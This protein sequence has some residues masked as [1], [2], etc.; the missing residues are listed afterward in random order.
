MRKRRCIP[1]ALE[2]SCQLCSQLSVPCNLVTSFVRDIRTN[3]RHDE[4]GSRTPKRGVDIGAAVA[5]RSLPSALITPSSP[6][7]A[8]LLS[9]RNDLRATTHGETSSSLLPGGQVLR[10]VVDIYFQLIH[11]FPHTL[12]YK[13]RFWDDVESGEIPEMILLG[14]VALSLR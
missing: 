12:F 11:N 3:V 10:E 2:R 7:Q 5:P 1:L 13:P 14:M 8:L 4:S 6:F 9:S